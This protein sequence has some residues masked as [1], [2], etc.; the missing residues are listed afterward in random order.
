M[1]TAQEIAAISD[2]FA[3][4]VQ[5]LEDAVN[6]T[7]S[8]LV[9]VGGVEV[10]T[11]PKLLS[12]ISFS[13]DSAEQSAA[14]ALAGRTTV[15][16]VLGDISIGGIVSKVSTLP[17][18]ESADGT[19][20][21]PILKNG[22]SYRMSLYALATY[23]GASVSDPPPAWSVPP[24]ISGDAE[25]G[26][27]LTGDDGEYDFG[28]VSQRRFLRDGAP[29]SGTTGSLTYTTTI[30]DNFASIQYEVTLNGPGGT[31]VL[32]SAALGPISSGPLTLASEY[33]PALELTDFYQ[34]FGDSTFVGVGSGSGSDWFSQ[35]RTIA[36]GITGAFNGG[37]GGNNGSSIEDIGNGGV[38]GQLTAEITAR[39]LALDPTYAT[40]LAR[41]SF[42][43]GG[44]NDYGVGAIADWP[45]E[46]KGN[47]ASAAG[48]LTNGKRMFAFLAPAENAVVDGN[49]WSADH[50]FHQLDMA[51]TYGELAF[52]LARYLRFRREIEAPVGTAD[53]D[54]LAMG[55]IPYL[56]R[57]SVSHTDFAEVDLPAI[58]GSGNPSDLNYAE[59]Q[60]YWNTTARNIW[61]K[62]GASGSG[63]W[64]LADTKHFSKWGN[65]VIARLAGDIALAEEGN[66]PP[67]SPPVRLPV[68][69]DAANGAVVG[70]LPVIGTMTGCVLRTYDDQPVTDFAIS[71]SGEIT[72][73]TASALT[74]GET[75]LVAVKQNEHGALASPVDIFVTRPSTVTA[76]VL[77]T[78]SAPDVSMGGRAA[79]G[80]VDGKK[81]SGAVYFQTSA[82]GAIQQLVL[83][84]KTGNPTQPFSVQISSTGN[85]RILASDSAN[86]LIANLNLGTHKIVAGTPYW[87]LFAFD[88]ATGDRCV[89]L[90]ENPQTVPSI[91]N[92][93]NI[94]FA[95]STPRFLNGAGVEEYYDGTYPF[96]GDIGALVLVDDYIDWTVEANRRL[97]FDTNGDPVSRTPFAAIGGVTPRFEMWGGVGDWLW[98]TPDG[99]V[100]HSLLSIS[101]RARTLLS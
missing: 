2:K 73:N 32:K 83:F 100:D 76:P 19:E 28:T 92:G 74:E 46:A 79:H 21:I 23:L 6:G 57:G 69:A 5:T 26:S 44:L 88:F 78:I 84:N 50:R 12:D 37:E 54:A 22:V 65:A 11:L 72:K 10:R 7:P 45:A 70:Q 67:V 1:K 97:L 13:A 77:R 95:A 51:A 55:Q 64:E 35:F 71:A 42:Y 24:S 52:D 36:T 89:Y 81:I 8:D 62:L 96:T 27:T 80:M 9:T 101:H 17:A 43:G 25:V 93:S 39:V 99:R 33:R 68:A 4:N 14:V 90:T 38:G 16:S 58:E 48:A 91:T 75:R 31:T 40:Q 98:G 30:D 85:T 34:G 3:Q 29:I 15:E 49:K 94:P 18:V 47:Y 66:G 60:I 87:M 20:Y 82:I 86:T 56:Y 53:A 61:R 41:S 63:S 59:G